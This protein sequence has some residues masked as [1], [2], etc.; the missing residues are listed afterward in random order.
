MIRI[1]QHECTLPDMI[2]ATRAR[3]LTD[4]SDGVVCYVRTD[5]GVDGFGEAT[6]G[7]MRL[8]TGH[9]VLKAFRGHARGAWS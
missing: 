9:E 4:N 6:V 5:S 7:A 3:R 1:W 2:S 8:L